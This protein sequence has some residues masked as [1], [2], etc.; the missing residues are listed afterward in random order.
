MFRRPLHKIAADKSRE[1]AAF[2]P[3]SRTPLPLTLD[4]LRLKS[5]PFVAVSSDSIKVDLRPRAGESFTFYENLIR[6]DYLAHG[7]RLGAGATVVAM[8]SPRLSRRSGSRSN[9][10]A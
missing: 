6:R 3:H 10:S 8:P 2:W 5:A 7:I 1:I 4:T 9:V